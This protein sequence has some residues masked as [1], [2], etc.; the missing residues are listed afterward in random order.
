[1]SIRRLLVVQGTVVRPDDCPYGR[2]EAEIVNDAMVRGVVS[3][4]PGG[5]PATAWL[6]D[7]RRA[8]TRDSDAPDS[9]SSAE[10]YRN[11]LGP[12]RG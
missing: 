6:A 10:M 11:H 2:N 7:D 3:M 9:T 1:M 4:P 5:L 12:P 8:Q